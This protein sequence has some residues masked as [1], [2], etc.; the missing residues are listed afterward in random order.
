MYHLTHMQI[1]Y[2]GKDKLEEYYKE[3]DRIRLINK[4]KKKKKKNKHSFTH[5]RN[6]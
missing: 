2:L 6:S 3:A 5:E 4:A 1:Y